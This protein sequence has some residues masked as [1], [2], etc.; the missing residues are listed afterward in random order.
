MCGP[1]KI[2]RF[3]IYI[4]GGIFSVLGVVLMALS[5]W[6][7]RKEFAKA[8]NLNTLIVGFGVAFG[9]VLLIMGLVAW[10]A[11]K[12]ESRCF[13]CLFLIFMLIITLAFLVVWVVAQLMQ[14]SRESDVKD[15][16]TIGFA[17]A[18]LGDLQRVYPK[19]VC[20]GV[21]AKKYGVTT[22][23]VS[24]TSGL[25][26]NDKSSI[27]QCSK[28][29]KEK[30]YDESEPPQIYIDLA[31]YLEEKQECAGICNICPHP[32]YTD[33]TAH[34]LLPT[35]ESKLASIISDNAKIITG[36]SMAGVV[37]GLFIIIAL[38]CLCCHKNFSSKPQQTYT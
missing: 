2:W 9:T 12:C 20:G 3:T 1:I 33:C 6:I 34:T 15:I 25:L 5:I 13:I 30:I 27:D 7:S 14:S 31:K 36:V 21:D 16:C 37:I 4:S 24:G 17:S 29:D 10:A 22:C 19:T 35:C 18:W 26:C 23:G 28:E 8:T 11:V 38:F 32:M